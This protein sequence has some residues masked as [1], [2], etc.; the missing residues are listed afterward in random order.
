MRRILALQYASVV[1]VRDSSVLRM[2]F[3]GTLAELALDS[4][5]APVFLIDLK[6]EPTSIPGINCERDF[7]DHW[8][9]VHLDIL[10]ED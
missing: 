5:S 1:M 7:K 2:L 4:G 8:T 3:G 6:K 10:V 9:P